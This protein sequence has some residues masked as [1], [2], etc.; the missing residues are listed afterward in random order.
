MPFSGT[1]SGNLPAVPGI[2]TTIMNDFFKLFYFLL[3]LT[4]TVS[5]MGPSGSG[6]D[7]GDLFTLTLQK[8]NDD[9]LIRIDTIR[10]KGS[11]TA[12]VVMDMWDKHWC[13][14]FTRKA[15][16]MIE[17]MNRTL[18]AARELGITVVFS[19][20]GVTHFYSDQAQREVMKTLPHHTVPDQPFNPPQAP[21]THTGGCECGPDRPCNATSGAVWTRQHKELVIK[22]GDLISEDTQELYNLCR[23]RGIS[24]LLYMGVASNMCILTRPTGIIE[25]SRRGLDCIIVRD[26]SEAISGNGYNP[27][28]E[29]IE[30]GFSPE[31]GSR[32]VI[33][34]IE[35]HIAPSISANQLFIAADIED[36]INIREEYAENLFTKEEV[37]NYQANGPTKRFRQLCYDYNWQGRTLSDLPK[38]FTKADPSEYAEFSKRMNLDGALVLAVPHPGYCTYNTDIGVKFPGM[39]GDWFGEVIEE[40]HTRDISAFG[41][42]TV[43]TNWKFMLDHIGKPYIHATFDETGVGPHEGL[44]FNAREYRDLLTDYTREVLENYPVDAMRY[45][46]LFS[47]KDCECAG[48]KKLYKELFG[49]EFSTWEKIEKNYPKRKDLLYLETLNRTAQRLSNACREIK[50]SLEIWQNHINTYSEADVNLGRI[51]DVA[52]IE[53]GDPFRLLS[54]RGILNKDAI[55]VGQTLTNPIRRLIMAL[56]ARCYQ[57]VPVDQETILPYEKDLDWFI[58]DLSPFYKMVSEIQAYLEDAVLPTNIGLVFSENTRYHFPEFNR[59]Q[60]MLACEGITMNYLDSSIPVQFINCLDLKDWDLD[61]Y[62]LLL[63]PRTAGLTPD[64]LISLKDYVKNGG[65]LLVIGDA[66]LYD[67]KGDHRDNFSLT[68]ELGLRFEGIFSDSLYADIKIAVPEI[69]KNTA[70]PGKVQLAGLIQTIAISGQT[71]VST[72]INSKEIP[73]LHIN[74]HGKGTIAYIATT[75]ST[76]LIRQTGDFLTGSM[77]IIVSDPGKQVILSHQEKLNRYVLHLLGEGDYSVFIDGDLAVI[78]KPISQY[79]LSGWE[80]SSSKIKNGIQIKVNGNAE[81][82][83]LVLQ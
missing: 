60:Y 42:I 7:D 78:D 55:I 40:L 82:R 83:L 69:K 41:Y 4:I 1:A 21:W 37:R 77:T 20:S 26:M 14:S 39:K 10:L 73:I 52:Y 43:G 31:S 71:L 2:L 50:P 57:Y 59:E 64:E 72:N 32:A 29:T 44:C 53:F 13:E 36:D 46:M 25:M 11:Q 63:L 67:E 16:A 6:S 38:K 68:E 74:K 75:A 9:G 12:V 18:N 15:V 3:A 33:E 62:N 24:T 58:N 80:Y 35:Q 76:E 47:P 27:D 23:E 81:N 51:F 70:L 22:E 65:T 5:C 66:L 30:P 79:P 34:H 54:L 61:R 49:A 28:T 8:R 48:C 56:G 19:P 17:P 45:D